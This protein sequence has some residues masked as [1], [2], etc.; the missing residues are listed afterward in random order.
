M[1][2]GNARHPAE[3]RDHRLALDRS[4]EMKDGPAPEAL[5]YSPEQQRTIRQGL[6]ILVRIAVRAHVQQ[7]S[8][9]RAQPSQGLVIREEGP[10]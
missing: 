4:M 6:R 3:R 2:T 10:A 8:P 9:S 5:F 7:P 1:T